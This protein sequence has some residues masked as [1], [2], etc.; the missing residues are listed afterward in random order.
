MESIGL[1]SGKRLQTSE[2]AIFNKD[3]LA[4]WLKFC[5]KLDRTLSKVHQPLMSSIRQKGF[6][7]CNMLARQKLLLDILLSLVWMTRPATCTYAT[8]T[9]WHNK[10][11]LLSLRFLYLISHN[12]LN[13]VRLAAPKD[14]IAKFYHTSIRKKFP[15]TSS[16]KAINRIYQKEKPLLY[17][18]K[19]LYFFVVYCAWHP[20][21]IFQKPHFKLRKD[22]ASKPTKRL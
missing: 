17:G 6:F 11:A 12:I 13:E 2:A 18:T 9:W 14:E 22:N 16:G 3:W 15:F 5:K 20:G 10:N 8:N 1:G 21:K 19:M 4:L 7:S